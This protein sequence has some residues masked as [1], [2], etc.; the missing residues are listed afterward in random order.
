MAKNV[1]FSDEMRKT[2]YEGA[3]KVAKVVA[4]TIGPSGRTVLIDG[5]YSPLISRDGVTVAKNI[6]LADPI[7]NLGASLMKN[8]SSNTDQDAGDGTS[9]ATV[10]ADAILSEGLKVVNNGVN[11]IQVKRGI[12]AAVKDIVSDLKDM[13]VEVE[14]EEQIAQVAAIS[15]NNDQELGKLIADSISKVGT[16]GVVTTAESNTGA[17]FMDFVEGMAFDRGYLSPYFS[18]D[19]DNLTVE[20]NNPYILITDKSIG[21]IQT[22]LPILDAISREGRP[23]L[24]IADEIENEVLSALIVNSLRGVIKV[25]AVKSPGFGDR[26]KDMMQD[27]AILTGGQLITEDLGLRLET[28][29]L[30]D[31]GQA[32]SVKV[33]KDN[34]TIIGGQGESKNIEA[35]VKQI[36][37]QIDETTSDYDR[38]KLQ[39]RLARLAGGVAVIKVGDVSET[40][41]K[42]KK[43]RI[44]DALNATRAAISEG[45]IPGG[46]TA[47]CQI[48]KKRSTHET[49]KTEGP[50]Y[51]IGYDIVVN[52]I[53]E[54]IKQIAE[55]A[56]VSG[57]VVADRVKNLDAGIG[58][59]ALTG[60]YV[61]MIKAGVVD[62][63]KVTRLAL[64]NA[65]SV[66]SLII[67][68]SASIT[69]IP[70]KNPPAADGE[71]VPIGM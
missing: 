24:I 48:S 3:H 53:Q 55:N 31:L 70:E 46:G 47:L 52:A 69:T 11:P 35:R 19:R 34:T 26:K 62:P 45:I 7:E 50:G 61:D 4:S 67:T 51:D 68:S 30:A 28:S 33:T 44:E 56:G 10:I 37:K 22:I 12:D 27:I 18:T 32:V 20:Y 39:E 63:V 23:L 64:Q 40:A 15:A 25:C 9:T 16:A 13:T 49:P 36:Q 21:N 42:E 57:E 6:D 59:N 58:Y 2:V 43:F 29:T 60:E 5:G 38:E 14:T 17:T 65:A 41:L 54:P 1:V 66:A 8:I 71:M